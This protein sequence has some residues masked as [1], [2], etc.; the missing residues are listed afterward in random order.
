MGYPYLVGQVAAEVA[1]MGVIKAEG[2]AGIAMAKEDHVRHGTGNEQVGAHIK[3]L[4]I[5]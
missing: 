2:E 1:G 4:P 3:L 5:Q